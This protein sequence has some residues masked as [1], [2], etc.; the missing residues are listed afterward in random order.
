VF[1]IF[2]RSAYDNIFNIFNCEFTKVKKKTKD[3][4]LKNRNVKIVTTI[5]GPPTIIARG[6]FAPS[7]QVTTYSLIK[8]YVC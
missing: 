8:A 6:A 7:S 4:F 2:T 1:A 3:F 5:P